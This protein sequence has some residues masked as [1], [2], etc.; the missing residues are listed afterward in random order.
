[1]TGSACPPFTQHLGEMVGTARCAFAHP[2]EF[3]AAL[4]LNDR[5]A[6]K[7]FARR[8]NVPHPDGYCR[9]PQIRTIIP[10][11]RLMQRGASRSSRTLSAGCDGRDIAADECWYRV[12]RN[13]A[14]LAPRRWR[15]VG[16]DASHHA[17][18]GGKKAR[19]PGRPRISRKTIA[20]G[21]PVA[22]AE[23]VVLPRAFCCTRTTGASRH[24]AF[25]APS[26]KFEGASQAKL[27]RPAPRERGRTPP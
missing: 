9:K 25:P 26:H 15:Q 27:G 18:D 3:F 5:G 7:R 24:P 4:L 13:R 2:T 8:A 20:Q 19:S 14:V 22:P 12:R 10:T 1:M 17:D 16:D 11:S 23:P 6:S 21:R